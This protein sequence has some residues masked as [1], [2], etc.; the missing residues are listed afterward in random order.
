M[1]IKLK[2]FFRNPT[3]KRQ[4]SS[5]HI[6]LDHEKEIDDYYIECIKKSILKTKFFEAVNNKIYL[7]SYFGE[8]S[9]KRKGINKL[10]MQTTIEKE[11]DSEY[12]Y[13]VVSS[14]PLS[15]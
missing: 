8:K 6:I 13:T 15:K 10:Y 4:G 9:R 12:I 7:Y 1:I 2:S 5:E 3:P 14:Y 11:K